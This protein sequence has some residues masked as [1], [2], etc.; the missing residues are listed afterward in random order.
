[1]N[2]IYPG[3]TPPGSLCSLAVATC[4]CV[5]LHVRM[6]E[7]QCLLPSHIPAIEKTSYISN[8]LHYF[9][10]HPCVVAT[11]LYHHATLTCRVH[12]GQAPPQLRVSGHAAGT[13]PPA[14][15]CRGL[16]GPQGHP[17]RSLSKLV[18]IR[19]GFFA[20]KRAL[21]ALAQ[22]GGSGAGPCE[23]SEFRLPSQLM[24]L[25]RRGDAYFGGKGS[26]TFTGK[27][28]LLSV[29]RWSHAAAASA[30]THYSQGELG[31]L[32]T[33]VDEKRC[34]ERKPDT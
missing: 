21:G 2:P 29:C 27:Q 6:Y 23:G 1:M 12:L 16:N 9:V 26:Q 33:G 15:L 11:A 8:T 32:E 5:C 18:I 28:A 34:L 31:G 24:G 22:S 19:L 20:P 10:T 4:M 3:I 14:L 13:G 7:W 30:V 17:E 25:Q